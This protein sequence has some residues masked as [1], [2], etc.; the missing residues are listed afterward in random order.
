MFNGLNTF[1]VRR[2]FS[3]CL[4]TLVALVAVALSSGSC[5]FEKG[6]CP[7]AIRSGNTYVTLAINTGLTMTKSIEGR[8]AVDDSHGGT[9]DESAIHSVHVWAFSSQTGHSVSALGY[10][11]V[12]FDGDVVSGSG[13]VTGFGLD[14]SAGEFVPGKVQGDKH[15]VN[16]RIPD[17]DIDK[18]DLYVIVNAESG[19]SLVK[20]GKLVKNGLLITRDEL[21][22]ATFTASFGV[23]SDGT[24]AGT[25]MMTSVPDSGLPMSGRVCGISLADYRAEIG[26]SATKWIDIPVIR[27]VT[28]LQFFF[29]KKK[30]VSGI[31][32][33]RIDSISIA[34]ADGDGMGQSNCSVPVSEYVFSDGDNAEVPSDTK[35]CVPLEFK[36]SGMDSWYIHSAQMKAVD[37]PIVYRRDAS[38][39]AESYLQRLSDANLTTAGMSYYYESGKELRGII[40]YRFSDSAT[41]AEKRLKFK[42]AS[43]E[44]LRNRENI[45]YM[46]VL[47]GKVEVSTTLKY[48][49][50]DWESDKKSDIKFN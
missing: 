47:D 35:Y 5:I 41:A 22:S 9:A 45:I 46:Y 43:G 10:T 6:E 37:D 39:D 4:C 27:A 19:C 1:A 31:E 28:K 3:G 17:A 42:I 13:S 21:E 24:N 18:I 29:A 38:E 49:V 7:E 30:G 12:K 8:A 32:K 36:S 23:N 44:F 16:V 48:Q 11:Y 20:D 14:D 34:E 26:Q 40:S 50:V 25:P 15:A 33:F 2:D